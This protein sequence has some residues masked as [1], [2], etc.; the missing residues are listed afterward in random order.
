MVGFYDQRYKEIDAKKELIKMLRDGG[1][2]VVLLPKVYHGIA[3]R[4]TLDKVYAIGRTYFPG[5]SPDMANSVAM[6]FVVEKFVYL[7]FPVIIPGNS[8]RAGGDAQKFKGQCAQISEVPFLPKYTEEN[9]ENFI[10][11]VWASETIMPE[12]ACKSLSYMGRY[13]YVQ[14][15]LNK[16]KLLAF[17]MVGHYDMKE[18]AIE[19]STNRVLF[20]FYFCKFMFS[21][22]FKAVFSKMLLTIFGITYSGI[23]FSGGLFNP[24][25]YVKII[26]NV[27]NIKDAND[28]I[29]KKEKVFNVN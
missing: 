29:M 23:S 25:N 5:P 4:S 8:I 18:L 28:Y 10:P 6:S 20:L 11:K 12:S 16:Q 19:K 21:K 2:E 24:K 13:D 9:W 3:K 1:N 27:D 17:F 7:N 26:K 15:Y 14:R 22:L